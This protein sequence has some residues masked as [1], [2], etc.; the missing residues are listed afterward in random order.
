[1]VIVF[2]WLMD[3]WLPANWSIVYVLIDFV[4]GMAAGALY[5][6]II[7]RSSI[8]SML[9]GLK[10]KAKKIAMPLEARM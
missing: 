4:I 5:Y 1:M 2:S 9:F 3:R 10:P 8:A 7:K 6:M